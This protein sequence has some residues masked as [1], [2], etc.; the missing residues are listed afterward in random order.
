MLSVP[1]PG[2]GVLN[3]AHLVLDFNG[4]LACDGVL[5]PGV[6]ERLPRLT[7]TLQVHVLTG[8]TFGTAA[9]FLMNM[10]CTLRV[11]EGEQQAQAKADHVQQLG[12]SS[13]A[14]IGN[15]RNDLLMMRQAALA[16]AVM[17][18]EGAHALTLMESD[19]VVASIG[20]ALDLLLRPLRLVATLRG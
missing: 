11:L 12:A 8:D 17:Q 3:L 2:S 5:L 16:V 7:Q 19:I 14:C 13:V 4:T 15:G 9:S 10:P 18:S 20:D 1:V 6:R